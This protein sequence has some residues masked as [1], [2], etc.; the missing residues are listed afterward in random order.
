MNKCRHIEPADLAVGIGRDA[1]PSDECT[2]FSLKARH[3]E[4]LAADLQ[5][6]LQFMRFLGRGSSS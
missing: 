2:V 6:E 1:E 5:I 3:M 4:P